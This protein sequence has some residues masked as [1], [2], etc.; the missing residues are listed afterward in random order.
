MLIHI[1]NQILP[2][3]ILPELNYANKYYS[4]LFFPFYKKKCFLI[5]EKVC[6]K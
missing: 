6:N 2:K 4:Y 3:R 1:L 5:N